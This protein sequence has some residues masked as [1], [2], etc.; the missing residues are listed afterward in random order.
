MYYSLIGCAVVMGV[1][2]IVSLLTGGLREM[3]TMN[4]NLLV[5]LVKDYVDRR[6][7]RWH[8]RNAGARLE[9]V[10]MLNG[11]TK[12]TNNNISS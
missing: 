8:E 6:Q 9:A 1:G 10:T 7:K 3:D 12:H 11:N 2:T 5:P 4:T